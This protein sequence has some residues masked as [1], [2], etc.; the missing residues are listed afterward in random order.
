MNPADIDML[1]LPIA[2][3]LLECLRTALSLETNPPLNICLRA[4]DSVT[5]DLGQ[6]YDE[7]C[8][9]LAWVRPAGFYMSGTQVSPFPS[10]STDEAIYACGVPAWGLNLEMGVL[11]CVKSSGRLSC[12]DWNAAV[13]QQLADAK[14]MRA[15]VCCLESAHDPGDIALGTW[16]PIGP[17][18][19]CLGSS[20][21]VSFLVSN[22]CE[23]DCG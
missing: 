12:E 5:A 17:A 21:D 10:P 16:T 3:E 13:I 9:G 4:G 6:T 7:C 22:V 11:R 14:A 2:L 19:G 20:W 15:A 18:G 1:L 23:V 8:E